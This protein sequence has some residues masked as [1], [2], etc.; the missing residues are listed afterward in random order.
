MRTPLV[1]VAA[2]IVGTATACST[3]Q[4]WYLHAPARADLRTSL[5]ATGVDAALAAARATRAER[6]SPITLTSGEGHELALARLHA[7]A[8]LEGPLALTELRLT[9][10]NDEARVREG[11]FTVTLPDGASVSRWAMRVGGAW[12]E[13][14]V[15]PRLRA[16][17]IYEVFLARGVDPALLEHDVGSQFSARVFPIAAATADRPGECEL[18]LSYT[19][20]VTAAAPYH[21]PLRGLPIIGDVDVAVTGAGP[22]QVVRARDWRPD[23]DLV[24]PGPV[25]P[26]AVG[27]GDLVVVRLDAPAAGPGLATAAPP[28]HLRILVDASASRALV[29]ARQADAVMAL[30]A[31]LAGHGGTVEIAAFDQ[32]VTPLYAGPA[33]GVDDRVRARLVDHG[34]LGAGDLERALRWAGRTAGA[35]PRVVLIGD[36]VATAGARAPAG[37]AAA[38]A[39]L[40]RLDAL[41]V[42]HGGDGAA[43]R[44]LVAAGQAPGVVLGADE[45]A[46]RWAERLATAVATAQTVA[47]AG[48]EVV[49]PSELVA[50]QPGDPVVLVARWPRGQRPGAVEVRLGGAAPVVV[51]VRPV[52]PALVTRQAAQAELDARR[53]ALPS[54]PAAQ[55][56][57]AELELVGLAVRHRLIGPEASLLVLESERDY[58]AFCLDRHALADV[59]VVGAHGVEQ[60]D[61]SPGV[62][63]LPELDGT[64]LQESGG[65]DEARA[66]APPRGPD[67]PTG[68]VDGVLIDRTSGD[69]LA[70]ATVVVTPS[71]GP[72][73]VTISD[74]AGRWR[75]DDVA[76]GRAIVQ[77]YYTDLQVR[78]GPV[79]V[80]AGAVTSIG[81]GPSAASARPRGG[82]DEPAVDPGLGLAPAG[83]SPTTAGAV[84]IDAS[85]GTAGESIAIA[86]RAPSIDPT[87]SELARSPWLDAAPGSRHYRRAAE[88]HLPAPCCE[89]ATPPPPPPHH[90]PFAAVVRALRRGDAAAALALAARWRQGAPTDVLALLALAEALEVG[91]YPALAARALGSI[92]DLYPTSAERLRLAAERLD[93]LGAAGQALAL[94]ALTRAAAERPDHVGGRRLLAYAQLRVGDAEAALATLVAAF[95]QARDDH[96]GMQQRL[97]RADLAIVAAAAVRA[98]P[99]RRAAVLALIGPTG[100]TLATTPEQ[101]VTLHW[102][103]EASDL[104]LHVLDRHGGH[105]WYQ[106]PALASGGGLLGDDTSGL[107]PEQVALPGVGAAGPYRLR[108]QYFGRGAMGTGLGTLHVVAHDGAGRVVQEHRPLVIMAEGAF[109]ELGALAWPVFGDDRPGGARPVSAA[110]GRA[111]PGG[112]GTARSAP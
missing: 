25:G 2:A 101:R 84:A 111:G 52:A 27:A 69:P 54:V 11:R 31:A 8:H 6:G 88:A 68:S 59:L 12:T 85:A 13:G 53:R 94:E 23:H 28:P 37:L 65:D 71:A 38:A 107:G 77:V 90:G 29:F 112:P 45:A 106:A 32:R 34:A 105:A 21:L 35:P 20:V 51:P 46:A 70:G 95:V 97:V 72:E 98:A 36:G 7:R 1:L 110:A 87:R 50:T 30:A 100:A 73:L 93:R 43:L 14:E 96:D 41:P 56:A 83:A 102:E 5:S 44:R 109:V 67:H 99:S 63:V 79:V 19:Q 66:P 58:R 16:R 33:A 26:D 40:G 108:A 104:D 49:W 62:T 60:V 80:R 74:E 9:F 17:Q 89:R 82:L 64:C 10:H 81:T 61:R 92:I 22:A 3:S 103:S 55:R 18:I 76:A 86:A 78:L 42:G 4:G 57:A 91:G 15:V 47:V 24:L 48:A 75:V 39:A